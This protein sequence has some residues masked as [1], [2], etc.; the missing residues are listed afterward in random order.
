M[1]HSPKNSQSEFYVVEITDDVPSQ[2]AAPYSLIQRISDS[3]TLLPNDQKKKHNNI[4]SLCELF[5]SEY[6]SIELLMVYL[7]EKN[8]QGIVDY[9]SNLLFEKRFDDKTLFYLP[10]LCSLIRGKDYVDPF[11]KYIISKSSDNPL[12]AVT[13]CWII[14]SYISDM[15]GASKKF[16]KIIEEIETKLINGAKVKD[17]EKAQ[18]KFIDK[19]KKLEHFDRALDL[20]EKL[21]RMCENLK[22]VTPQTNNGDKKSGGSGSSKGDSKKIIKELR[23]DLMVKTLNSFNV[24][25]DKMIQLHIKSPSNYLGYILPFSGFNSKVIV[26]FHPEISFCFST[27]AR[28][29]V[30]LT[31][32][33]V[34]ISEGK[35][36][37]DQ[38]DVLPIESNGYAQYEEENEKRLDINHDENQEKAKRILEHVKYQNE[39]PNEE[40]DDNYSQYTQTETNRTTTLGNNVDISTIENPFGEE[41]MK[42]ENEIKS[43]SRFRHFNSLTIMNF[44][45][46][47]NDDLRQEHMTMQLIKKFDEI[48]K[49]A[50]LPLK[51]RPYE[52]V[53]TSSSSGLIEFLPDTLS[54]DAIKHFLL[55]YKIP[56]YKF[57][58]EFYKEN[59]FTAQ[60]NFVESLA[61]YSIVCYLVAIKDRHNGNILLDR[62]GSIIHIDFGFILG[63]SPGGNLNFENAPFKLTK[64]YIRIMDGVN[65]E[66]YAYFKSLVVRGILEARKH[67]ESLSNIVEAMGRG[68]PMPC[69]NAGTDVDVVIEN[70]K[71][72]FL[73]KYTE[74]KAISIIDN[75]IAKSAKSWRTTQYDIFQKLTNDILP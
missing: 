28:V 52:I 53:I 11:L 60:K 74:D 12:F 56:F 31:V 20:Y 30:K 63:I 46:K 62:N 5:S 54:I 36:I 13:T 32:E 10:Q 1:K 66:I 55:P 42:K 17:F 70:F 73:L 35:A 51:L 4:G 19:T 21:K 68:V 16:D 25:I 24:N 50:N 69:F 47:A 23:K 45:A 18:Q 29:P 41:W 58:K 48:F 44:I 27:K 67:I 64:D 9:L 14:D 3:I 37:V 61:A 7:T 34:D 40:N 65:S 72:R 6:F 22:T 71:E 33:C 39:H 59:F 2:E 49:N 57:F 75:L 26:G 15:N 8:E 43:K 38:I